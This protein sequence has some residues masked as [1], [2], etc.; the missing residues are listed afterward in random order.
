MG[1][2]CGCIKEDSNTELETIEANPRKF[3]AIITIQAGFRGY[4]DRK[5]VRRIREYKYGS[6]NDRGIPSNY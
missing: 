3:R 4:M 1:N 5:K 6:M 2:A